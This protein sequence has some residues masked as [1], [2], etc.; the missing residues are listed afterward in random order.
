MVGGDDKVASRENKLWKLKVSDVAAHFSAE[1]IG[2]HLTF[3][4]ETSPNSG[5]LRGVTPGLTR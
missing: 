1:F 3:N 2:H 5:A 4:R